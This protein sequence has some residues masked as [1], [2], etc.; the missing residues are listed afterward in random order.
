MTIAELLL[1]D[2]DTEMAGTRRTLERIPDANPTFKPHEKSM[3][4]GR[5]AA[6]VATLPRLATLIVTSEVTDAPGRDWPPKLEFQ[7]TRELVDTFDRVAAE[8]RAA[9]AAATDDQLNDYWTL[10]YGGHVAI[11]GKRSAVYRTVFFNHL[12]HHRAQLGVYLRLNNL[13]VPGLYGPSADEPFI[14]K[15]S[16]AAG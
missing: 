9:L 2:F 15:P 12:L 3:A 1:Q 6:H 5:L 8:A 13:P 10:I 7:S 16:S 4:M 11:K 14:P